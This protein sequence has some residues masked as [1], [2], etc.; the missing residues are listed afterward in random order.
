[1]TLNCSTRPLDSHGHIEARFFLDD[2]CGH[3]RRDS[4]VR[5][6]SCRY[7]IGRD[8]GA[9]S[10]CYA[11]HNHRMSGDPRPMTE[12]NRGKRTRT[13]T[14]GTVL[15]RMVS[16]DEHRIRPEL[17]LVFEDNSAPRVNPATRS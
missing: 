16:G 15:Q 3:T 12:M 6:V 1:M 7:R 2:P 5:N 17:H 14:V 13:V 10:E 9:A 4:E 8:E 11:F